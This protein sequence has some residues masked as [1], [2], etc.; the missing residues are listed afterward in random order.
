M[1][2]LDNYLRKYKSEVI[3]SSHITWT[4]TSQLSGD[5]QVK[6]IPPRRIK[7]VMVE[8]RLDGSI[9]VRNNGSYF[10]YRE[11]DPELIRRAEP[12][13]KVRNRAGKGYIPPKDHP[14]RHFKIKTYSHQKE[15]K[16]SC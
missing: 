5:F 3:H 12:D 16:I 7:T 10:K 14:W 1:E 13:K 6:D 11:I 15:E 2:R 8:D 4:T 9:H